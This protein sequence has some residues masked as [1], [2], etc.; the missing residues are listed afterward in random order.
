MRSVDSEKLSRFVIDKPRVHFAGLL[1][2]RGL[3]ELANLLGDEWLHLATLLEVPPHA[4]SR[5]RLD[6]P[7]NCRRQIAEM[8]RSWRDAAH[9]EKEQVKGQLYEALVAVDRRDI[10]EQLLAEQVRGSMRKQRYNAVL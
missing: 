1:S 6:N 3:Y 2:D 9:G 8:L 4:V 10:G 7:N 5:L